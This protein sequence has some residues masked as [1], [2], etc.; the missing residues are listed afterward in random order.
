[1]RRNLTVHRNT[2]GTYATDLFTE[3]AIE[4][5]DNHN[6]S[7]PMFMML[8][9]LAPHTGN[10]YDPMQAPE[11]EINKFKYIQN[12]KRRTYAAMV[13]KLDNGVGKVIKA[14]EKNHML[15]NTIILFMSDNGSPVEGNK[16]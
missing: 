7:I 1:M 12:K 8:S 2:M 5:I 16:V 15:E 6:K 13:S 10:E 4:T 3:K 9:H 11:D 14:L